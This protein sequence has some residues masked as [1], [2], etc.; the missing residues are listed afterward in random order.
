MDFEF[1]YKMYMHELCRRRFT[2]F[3]DVYLV[4]YCN[5]G[6][7]WCSRWCNIVKHH[8]IYES[9][10]VIKDTLC[11]LD[12]W[13]GVS[14]LGYSGG[15]PLLHPDIVE[16]CKFLGECKLKYHL[17]SSTVQ[18][19]CKKLL[20]MSDEFFSVLRKYN[21][22]I[23][24]T[25]Y[26]KES[27]IDYDETFRR[28]DEEHISYRNQLI[29]AGSRPDSYMDEFD[30][31]KFTECK[32]EDNKFKINDFLTCFQTCPCLWQG[33]L[34][35]CCD[36]PFIYNL[37]DNF[38]T[39]FKLIENDDY[40]EVSNINKDFDFN[41]WKNSPSHACI[42]HCYKCKHGRIKWAKGKNTKEELI[43]AT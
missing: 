9:A 42:H 29:T 39:H 16:L 5:L 15:E 32:S 37:N 13:S 38:G 1:N 12:N 6:C 26:P 30:L 28:L 11:I 31:T 21:I 20:S 40:V 7:K 36:L 22:E 35:K 34:F 2:S 3:F 43:S 24:Y 4:N 23:V 27:G 41:K 18:T 8:Q 10:D 14:H 33:K 17:P 25:K 19:N